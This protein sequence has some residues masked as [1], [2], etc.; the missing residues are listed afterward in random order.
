MISA[1]STTTSTTTS[2]SV[3]ASSGTLTI[4]SKANIRSGPGTSFAIL[5]VVDV[6]TTLDITGV[7]NTNWYQVTYNGQTG[8]VAGNLITKN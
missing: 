4:A 7:T 3:T 2:V 6:G 5:G 8:F 1:A